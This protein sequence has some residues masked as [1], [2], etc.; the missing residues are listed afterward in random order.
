MKRLMVFAMGLGLVSLTGCSELQVIKNATLSEFRAEAVSLETLAQQKEPSQDEI[1][2]VPD[3][4][5]AKKTMVAKAE[6]N[7]FL[8][9][10]GTGTA[11]PRK[12]V[13]EEGK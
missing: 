7:P 11:T 12:G 3:L 1:L 8:A 2:A 10:A 13:W 4:R 6:Y 9:G 5:P